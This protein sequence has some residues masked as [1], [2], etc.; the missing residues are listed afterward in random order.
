MEQTVGPLPTDPLTSSTPPPSSTTPPSPQDPSLRQRRLL[1]HQGLVAADV[2]PPQLPPPPAA[3]EPARG[4]HCPP[5]P[6][7]PRAAHQP[8]PEFV[9]QRRKAPIRPRLSMWPA[10][11]AKGHSPWARTGGKQ[12]GSTDEGETSPTTPRAP[13]GPCLFGQA[14]EERP[15][16]ARGAPPSLLSSFTLQQCRH[17][18]PPSPCAGT[19][20]PGSQSK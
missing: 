8:C 13:V 3:L 11:G 10:G 16:S 18:A 7:R 19:P 5:P 4:Q 6:G 15:Q 17:T 12:G 1:Q 2:L 14:P 20:A 9:W